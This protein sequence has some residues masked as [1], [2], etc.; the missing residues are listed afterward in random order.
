M[1]L[2]VY[3]HE[4]FRQ[5]CMLARF[6]DLQVDAHGVGPPDSDHLGVVQLTPQLRRADELR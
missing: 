1:D 5:C 3:R 6:P 4:L 2:C